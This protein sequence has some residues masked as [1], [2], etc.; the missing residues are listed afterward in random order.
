MTGESL[1]FIINPPRFLGRFLCP[2]STCGW[3]WFSEASLAECLDGPAAL[4]EEELDGKLQDSFRLITHPKGFK[5]F[6]DELLIIWRCGFF[7]FAS[8]RQK[9]LKIP[10]RRFFPA[11]CRSWMQMPFCKA[12]NV[13][14]SAAECCEFFGQRKDGTEE[15]PNDQGQDKFWSGLRELC[16]Q[17][18]N[19]TLMILRWYIETECCKTKPNHFRP[20]RWRSKLCV[21]EQQF[22]QLSEGS[23]NVV[24]TRNKRLARIGLILKAVG[25]CQCC[26]GCGS[27]MAWPACVKKV[28]RRA[29]HF[30]AGQRR[31]KIH[32]EVATKP[33]LEGQMDAAWGC[34]LRVNESQLVFFLGEKLVE[35]IEFCVCVFPLFFRIAPET[36]D[37]HFSL[38]AHPLAD[39]SLADGPPCF[40]PQKCMTYWYHQL[41]LRTAEST[42]QNIP[43]P[44]AQKCTP[45]HNS[46]RWIMAIPSNPT[47][48]FP[49]R[50]PRNG[51]GTCHVQTVSNAS[52]FCTF[53]W[54]L[55]SLSQGCLHCCWLLLKPWINH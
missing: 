23:G 25:R 9:S 2:S 38:Q 42:Q 20:L 36:T 40:P 11:F 7:S 19:E 33:F 50:T 12:L 29:V 37:H 13:G 8:W 26:P 55:E 45:K 41:S 15:W 18:R 52:A 54:T 34:R 24:I 22:A 39:G 4:K 44:F 53:S 16:Q 51:W 47:I 1:L 21:Q 10:H 3:W 32:R 14:W 5:D 28:R 35:L 6:K 48:I 43:P 46:L 30:W 31:Q 17:R 49:P 27:C